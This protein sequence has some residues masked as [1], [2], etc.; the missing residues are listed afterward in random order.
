MKEI[1]SRDDI[2][3]LVGAFYTKVRKDSLLGDIFNYH[4]ASDE[5]PAHLSK[6]S[7]FWEGHL[8]QGSSFRGNPV[9]KH[10]KVDQQLKHT[11][12]KEH[13]DRWLALWSETLDSLYEGE[14]ADKAKLAAMRMGQAQ[15][16]V[17]QHNRPQQ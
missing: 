7:D 17:V 15:L 4:I 1:E 12:N 8:L 14:L 9:Q 11:M 3:R 10:I 16:S 6:L 2:V 13:F 5:W